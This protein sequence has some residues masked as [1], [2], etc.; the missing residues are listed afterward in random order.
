MLCQPDGTIG[1]DDVISEYHTVA[2][3]M[4]GLASVVNIFPFVEIFVAITS[5]ESTEKWDKHDMEL[6]N[7]NF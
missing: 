2:D 6:A 5:L 4:L 3:T 7:I 1:V